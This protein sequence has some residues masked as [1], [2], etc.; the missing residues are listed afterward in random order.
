MITL[1]TSC[2]N[3]LH[4]IL[5]NEDFGLVDSCTD[6]MASAY[7]LMSAAVRDDAANWLKYDTARFE[8]CLAAVEAELGQ[9]SCDHTWGYDLDDLFDLGADA[10][11]GI[12]EGTRTEGDICGYTM[13]FPSASNL[14]CEDDLDCW[15][16]P[17]TDPTPFV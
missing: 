12:I 8:T 5:L 17:S 13:P 4:T 2:P 6:G 3:G 1:E 9:L 7:W 14:A 15:F 16:D 11:A 10:C